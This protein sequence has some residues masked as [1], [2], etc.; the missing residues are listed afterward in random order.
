MSNTSNNSKARF[1]KHLASEVACDGRRLIEQAEH[2]ISVRDFAA[3]ARIGARLC[4]L[5]GVYQ[6]AG[7]MYVALALNRL[8]DHRAQAE[9]LL[10]TAAAKSSVCALGARAWLALGSNRLLEGDVSGAETFYQ[11]AV[12]S[13]S[14]VT[15]FCAELMSIAV[16]PSLESLNRIS[17]LAHYVGRVFPAYRLNYLNA[18]AVVLNREGHTDEARRIITPVIQSPLAKSFHEWLETAAEIRPRAGQVVV[19]SLSNVVE[20]PR[21]DRRQQVR[22]IERVIWNERI[23]GTQLKRYADGGERAIGSGSQL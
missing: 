12:R 2:A 20:F 14:V 9:E 1:I 10:L 5:S 19:P 7:E 15:R 16:R 13:D 17:G 4:E 3:V 23:D 18:V 11:K 6:L 8:P 22:R 21:V